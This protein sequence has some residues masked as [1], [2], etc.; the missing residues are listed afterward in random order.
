MT[1][2]CSEAALHFYLPGREGNVV[3]ATQTCEIYKYIA[4]DRRSAG[5][6]WFDHPLVSRLVS[7]EV[8]EDDV[9][10]RVPRLFRCHCFGKLDQQPQLPLP[11]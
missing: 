7:L 10:S 6:F 5:D 1:S 4:C 11:F 8:G 9:L 2:G 3:S